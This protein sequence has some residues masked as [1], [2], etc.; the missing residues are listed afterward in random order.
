MAFHSDALRA[1]G[2][3]EEEIKAAIEFDLEK[4]DIS[5]KEKR[6]VEFA[7]KAD[8]DPHGI[9]EEEFAE[10]RALSVT[11]AEIVEALEAMTLSTGLNRYCD[12]L[13]IIN[14]AWL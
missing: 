14:D 8:V 3:N 13:G 2:A 12:A 9:T 10:L 6:L 1:E 7:I 4:V 11:D 5:A